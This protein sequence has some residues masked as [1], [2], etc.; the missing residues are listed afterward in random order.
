[1]AI[2]IFLLAAGSIY[3]SSAFAFPPYRST[4][5]DTA[6]P[7]TIELRAGL[8][9]IERQHGHDKV[10]TPLLRMNLGLPGHAEIKTEL[11]YVPRNDRL[12]DAAIGAKWVPIGGTPAIGIE[13]L[14]LLPVRENDQG[15]GFEGQL[16]ATLEGRDAA[17]HV[18]GGGF[19]DPRPVSTEAG[20][21]G[22]VL[23]ELLLDR[24]RPGL[25]AFAK[26]EFGKSV[27]GRLGLGAIVDFAR[28]D[29][30][31]GLHAGVSH[32]APD[33]MFS[34]WITTKFPIR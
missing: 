18:N 14:A 30:R 17:I 8:F 34:L 7:G 27:D 6:E 31:A 11:E 15:V 29:V 23:V 28:F 3:W 5:A 12:G 24:F 33:V 4:D 13:T 1:V 26:Q 10:T 2:G 25:E 9:E 20:W 21:R 16:L 19:Y 32:E 22:S